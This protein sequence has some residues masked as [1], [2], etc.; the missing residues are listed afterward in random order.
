M[1]ASS[2]RIQAPSGSNA[3]GW[4]FL[5]VADEHKRAALA[6]CYRV[7]HAAYRKRDSTIYTSA[8]S[9]RIAD[10]VT[11]LAD[12]IQHVPLHVIPCIEGRLGRAIAPTRL[13][14]PSWRRS[15]RRRGAS[16]SPA[17]PARWEPVGRRCISHA[18]RT[19]QSC[20][21]SPLTM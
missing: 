1:C 13:S 17:V 5:V 12:N 16:R 21:A 15:S 6:E 7:G 14:P 19:W 11:Y 18:T 4:R 8:G 2:S 10:S 9:E 3:Q 20:S